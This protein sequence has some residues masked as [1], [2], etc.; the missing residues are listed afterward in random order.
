M[1][2]PSFLS[3]TQS[4]PYTSCRPCVPMSPTAQSCAA[5]VQSNPAEFPPLSGEGEQACLSCCGRASGHLRAS[6]SVTHHQIGDCL[7]KG[8][9]LLACDLLLTLRTVLW[10]RGRG[11][12][13]GDPG[14]ASSSQL[15]GFQTDLSSLRRLAQC[16]KQAQHKMFLHETTVR[17]MAG[18]S[19]TRTHRLLEH[20]LRCRGHNLAESTEQHCVPG[21]RERAHAI[22]LACR[23]LPLPLLTPPGHRAHLLAEAQRTLERVGDRRSVRDC[24]H[25]LLRLSGVPQWSPP[26]MPCTFT[27]PGLRAHARRLSALTCSTERTDAA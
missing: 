25:I 12:T 21:E 27:E 15:A 22:L 5:A 24:Q 10:Q 1:S 2:L 23:H 26:D 11:G 6:I 16:Y 3:P 14:P 18:A 4:P 8:V 13:W 20:S 19:P 7:S 9:E 17:L